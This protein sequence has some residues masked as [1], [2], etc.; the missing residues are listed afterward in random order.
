MEVDW[1]RCGNTR[2]RIKEG[3]TWN[4]KGRWAWSSTTLRGGTKEALVVVKALG[5]EA[6]RF[7]V[8]RLCVLR[9]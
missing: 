4:A 6:S 2:Q 8:R 9:R 5:D 7:D 3:S 1:V